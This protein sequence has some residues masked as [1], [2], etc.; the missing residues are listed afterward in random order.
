M[1]VYFAASLFNLHERA[2]NRHLA[3]LIQAELPN[4]E[5]VLPQT[6]KYHGKFNDP[7]T[8]GTIYQAC[9]DGV[10]ESAAVIAILDG[11][12]AD[13]GTAFEVGYAVAL[14][15][16]VI[17]VRT[18][19]RA[20][21][22]KGMNLMLSRGCSVIIHRPAFDEDITAL[23]REISRKLQRILQA[24]PVRRKIPQTIVTKSG[25]TYDV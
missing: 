20:S 22:E 12:S 7:K 16:P 8:F 5:I 23:A 2:F 21:Q 3:E 6:F 1:K 15:I 17:G 4:V 24:P 18:D 10:A 11:P 13:D 9:V 14:G 25:S 19:Y